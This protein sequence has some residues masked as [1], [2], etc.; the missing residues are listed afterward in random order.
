MQ[1]TLGTTVPYSSSS[2]IERNKWESMRQKRWRTEEQE[3]TEETKKEKSSGSKRRWYLDDR[4]A[5]LHQPLP[6]VGNLLFSWMVQGT[7]KENVTW[8]RGFRPN[9]IEKAISCCPVQVPTQAVS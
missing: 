9:C 2:E 4:R 5:M 1:K 7:L 6:V 8:Q 3:D